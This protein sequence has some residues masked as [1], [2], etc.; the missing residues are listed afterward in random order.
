MERSTF[1]GLFVLCIAWLMAGI[2]IIDRL[3]T[4]VAAGI[5][6]W[7]GFEM[8]FERSEWG[9]IG[10]DV[11]VVVVARIRSFMRRAGS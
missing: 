5:I 1:G 3:C 8:G 4:L 7:D 10:A 6:G 9:R 11:L 2:Y